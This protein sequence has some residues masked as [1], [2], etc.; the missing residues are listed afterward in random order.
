MC[1]IGS[2]EVVVVLLEVAGAG[3]GYKGAVVWTA[4]KGGATDIY[5]VRVCD[6][7]WFWF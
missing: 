6:V 4:G 1:A 5:I 3:G 2:A 7:Y